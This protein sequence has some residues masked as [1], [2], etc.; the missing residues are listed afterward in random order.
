ME[1][2][3]THPFKDN[4]DEDCGDSYDITPLN[5][6][7]KVPTLVSDGGQAIFGSQVICGYLG[8]TALES[9]PLRMNREGFHWC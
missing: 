1:R 2:I 4:D 7:D 3:A 9:F 5:P 8:A 6:F